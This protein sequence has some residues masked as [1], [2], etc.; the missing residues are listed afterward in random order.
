M[1]DY[2]NIKT[3]NNWCYHILP[4]VYDDSLSY[5][6]TL[7]KVTSAVNDL[8]SNNDMIPQYVQDQITEQLENLD[9]GNFRNEIVDTVF[10]SIADNLQNAEYAESNIEKGDIFYLNDILYEAISDIETGVKF[11]PDTNIKEVKI[12]DYINN[13]DSRVST[14]EDDI[15]NNQK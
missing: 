7:C 8:I 15:E 4:L 11:L 12:I 3:L 13:L 2:K 1:S 10:K 9:E 14:N 5:Y 6:E